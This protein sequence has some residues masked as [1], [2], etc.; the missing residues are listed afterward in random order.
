MAIL[1]GK[2]SGSGSA[3][4]WGE[5]SGSGEHIATAWGVVRHPATFFQRTSN[6][7]IM[8]IVHNMMTSLM[9][10]T[11]HPAS[12]F[13]AGHSTSSEGRVRPGIRYNGCNRAKRRPYRGAAHCRNGEQRGTAE[14]SRRPA[15]AGGGGRRRRAR[16]RSARADGIRGSL[17]RNDRHN[18]KGRNFTA[19]TAIQ[20]VR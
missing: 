18:R 19:G 20:V 5:G 14:P 11:L 10:H 4:A 13:Q 12:W 16:A 2:G 17:H 7:H 8:M 6:N 3:T 1:R 9:I 15:A